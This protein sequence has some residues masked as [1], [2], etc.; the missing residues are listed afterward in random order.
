MKNRYCR[1]VLW[2]LLVMSLSV[3]CTLPTGRVESKNRA[4]IRYWPPPE[5]TRKLRLAVKDLIDVKGVVTTAGS[6][7]FDKRGVPA[8]RDAECLERARS[9]NVLI[10]GKTNLTEFGFGGSA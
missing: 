3:G 10:V 9:K 5:G 6:K 1:A 7:Y 2:G 4:F 8:S